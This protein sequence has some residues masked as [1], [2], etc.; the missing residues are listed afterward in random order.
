MWLA[1]LFPDDVLGAHLNYIPGSF[2][3]HVDEESQPLTTE[4]SRFLE[5]ASRFAA[6]EGAYAALQAT[7]PQT[8]AFSLSD[9]PVGLAAWIAEKFHAWTDRRDASEYGV[10]VDGLLTDIALYW[11]SGSVDASLRLYKGNRLNPLAFGA[12][13]R[14]D[15]PLGVAVF[16]RELPMPPRCW[17]ERVFPVTQWAEMPEGGHFAAWE[18][19]ELLAEEIR[20]FFRPLREVRRPGR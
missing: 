9:S 18:Q 1:R 4:E 13:E 12:G 11:F 19:P 2:R 8:L 20:R 16:P 7:K 14:V 15:V 3:P 6:E 17:V 10:P 5:R